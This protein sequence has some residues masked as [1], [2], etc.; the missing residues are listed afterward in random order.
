MFTKDDMPLRG[1][2]YCSPKANN[3]IYLP[4]G[5]YDMPEHSTERSGV[6]YISYNLLLHLNK[7]L[8]PHLGSLITK[9]VYNG[10]GYV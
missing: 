2:I 10:S 6:N 3:T 7:R 8:I 1:A 4:C 5:R 9:K